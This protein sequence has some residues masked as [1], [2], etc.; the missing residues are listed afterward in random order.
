MIKETLNINEKLA[1]T[2]GISNIQ[3]HILNATQEEMSLSDIGKTVKIPRSTLYPYVRDLVDRGFLLMKKKSFGGMYKTVNKSDLGNHLI[4]TG[5]NVAGNT[6]IKVPNITTKIQ[7]FSGKKE[8]EKIWLLIGNQPIGSR[9]ICIQP[10]KSLDISVPTVPYKI[11]KENHNLIIKRKIF[12]EQFTEE[13]TYKTVLN[14]LNDMGVLK[15]TLP[16]F[17]DRKSITYEFEAD[18]LNSTAEL[19]VVTEGIILVDR[20]DMFGILIENV[21]IKN[22]VTS[23]VEIIKKNMK[24]IDNMKELTENASKILS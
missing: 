7:L 11:V 3:M 6:K 10:T 23:L 13:G 9:V 15:E 24:P 16:D 4:Q 1:K 22:L 2:I 20:E 8:M 5:L 14:I 21:M 12:L 19:F 17:E 18:A